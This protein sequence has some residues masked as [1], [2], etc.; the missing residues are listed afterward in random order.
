VFNEYFGDDEELPIALRFVELRKILIVEF[1]TPVHEMTVQKFT[2]EFGDAFGNHRELGERGSMTA[3]RGGNPNKEADTTFGPKRNTV[4][5]TRPPG[6]LAIEKWVTLAIDVARTQSWDSLQKTALWWYGYKGIQ[7]ILLLKISEDARDMEYYLYDVPNT[8]LREPNILRQNVRLLSP[9][10]VT[11]S[12]PQYPT[13]SG[14]FHRNRRGAPENVTFSNRRIL[15]I[16]MG[17]SLPAGVH[18]NTVVNLRNVMQQVL[19]SR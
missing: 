7:Y 19:E 10:Q 5:R 16:P 1:P 11:T 6:N 13:A 4:N 8:A 3:R 9:L 12:L 14:A 17:R 15:S 2:R 18:E